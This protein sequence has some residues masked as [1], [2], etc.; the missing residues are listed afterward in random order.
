M[1]GIE[2]P[3]VSE[4]N[5][6]HDLYLNINNTYHLFMLS[7]AECCQLVFTLQLSVLSSPPQLASCVVEHVFASTNKLN[8]RVFFCPSYFLCSV[9]TA[10]PVCKFNCH[11]HVFLVLFWWQAAGLVW[12]CRSLLASPF[13]EFSQN[14][15]PHLTSSTE[16]F[17]TV[18]FI[19]FCV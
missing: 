13:R 3:S 11:L 15:G 19:C 9:L 6:M 10:Q 1:C 5:K 2:K 12:C 7:M 14:W 8:V 16:G 4:E 18:V 17:C